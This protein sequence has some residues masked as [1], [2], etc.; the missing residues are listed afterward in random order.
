M[1][2][3]LAY[4]DIIVVTA[5]KTKNMKTLLNIL[6]FILV[7]LSCFA[8]DRISLSN[9]T[10]ELPK[11]AK[12][13]TKEQALSHISKKFNNDKVAMESVSQALRFNHYLSKDVLISFNTS[14]IAKTGDIA[15]D[16]NHLLNMKKGLDELFKGNESYRSE[17]KNLADKSI[18]II[19]Y[20]IGSS[21]CIRFY[22]FNKEFTRALTGTL[23]FN[24]DNQDEAKSAMNMI[25]KTLKFN[26]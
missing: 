18:V 24:K 12:K 10:L 2:L 9:A 23:V 5:I 17:I 22:S 25:E 14:D 26:N 7:S 21:L 6:T 20:S 8:Q 11:G 15:V 16:R 13:I 3:N 1:T 19:Q 4:L